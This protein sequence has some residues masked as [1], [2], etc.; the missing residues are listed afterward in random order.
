MS[1]ESPPSLSELRERIREIDRQLVELAAERVRIAREIGARKRSDGLPTVDYAQEREVLEAARRRSLRAGLDA[2]VAED[3]VT[4]LIQ[5]SVGAQEE[6]SLRHENLG[7]GRSAVVLGGAGRMGRWMHRFLAAQGWAVSVLDPRATRAENREAEARLFSAELVLL[8]TPPGRTVE[9]YRDW[10]DEPP[11]GTLIDLASIKT[12]LIE[13][14]RALQHAGARVGSIHPMFGPATLLLRDADVA[15][16]DTGD[17]EALAM[18]EALFSPTTARLVPVPLEDHDRVMADLLSLAH[19][20]AIA[21][22][23]A[24]PDTEHPVHSTTFQALERLAA[25]VVRE[26]PDVYYEIQAENPHSLESLGRLRDSLER[27]R[28]AVTARS[29]DAFRDLLEEGRRRTPPPSDR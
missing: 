22:A 14:I 27:V 13:P 9:L 21:F 24:L 2:A 16:C 18:V 3:L 6:D 25:A 1:D 17:P 26:S 10:A 5:A 29:R 15:L 19:A 20:C 23:L 11:R 12:P 7:R 4:R 28:E 8:A